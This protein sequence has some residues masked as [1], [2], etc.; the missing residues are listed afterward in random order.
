[1]NTETDWLQAPFRLATPDDAAAMADLVNYAGEGLPDYLWS[2]MA[3]DGQSPREVGRERARRESGSFSWRN[4]VLRDDDGEVSAALIG[5]P[6]PDEPDPDAYRDLPPMFVPLQQLEDLAAGSWYINVLAVYPKF[7]GRGFGQSLLEVAAVQARR[8]N[9][10]GLSL[11]VSNSNAG[12]ARLYQ[13]MG[14]SEVARRPVVSEDWQ[15][16]A[17]EWVL[18]TC[19]LADP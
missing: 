14:Y 11:I 6:L 7:R 2:R 5:Y 19:P 16:D 3:E 10:R 8:L 13:R 12:A 15:T 9:C 4:T 18:M 1:M 17:T